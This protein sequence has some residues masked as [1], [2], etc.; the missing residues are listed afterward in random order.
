MLL[1]LTTAYFY[2]LYII[3]GY[4]TGLYMSK[5]FWKLKNNSVDGRLTFEVHFNDSI[6]FFNN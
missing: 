3:Y 1:Q 4:F 6:I 2:G 5:N